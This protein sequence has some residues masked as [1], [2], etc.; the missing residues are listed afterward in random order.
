MGRAVKRLKIKATGTQTH[1]EKVVGYWEPSFPPQVGWETSWSSPWP[2]VG[3]SER[4]FGLSTG[5]PGARTV[6]SGE[7]RAKYPARLGSRQTQ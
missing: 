5:C 2:R 6:V 3:A 7:V 4:R 1:Q